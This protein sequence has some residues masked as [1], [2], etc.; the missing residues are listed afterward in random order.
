MD[1]YQKQSAMENTN[2]PQEPI[3]TPN[4]ATPQTPAEGQGAGSV[5]AQDL[6]KVVAELKDLRKKNAELRAV[7]EGKTEEVKPTVD[8]TSIAEAVKQVLA[9]EKQAES[10]ASIEASK[11]DALTSFKESNPLFNSSNDPDGSKFKVIEDEFNE[12]NLGNATTKE[13]FLSYL[14][15]ASLLAGVTV[16]EEPKSVSTPTYSPTPASKTGIVNNE[17][18]ASLTKEERAKAQKKGM[19]EERFAELKEK[20]PNMV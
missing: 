19:S 4:E 11:A 6:D 16:P 12:F 18:V 10:Q 9:A 15:K 1:R 5:P 20:Y 17:A 2:K 14:G 13:D 7:A 8:T 3:T